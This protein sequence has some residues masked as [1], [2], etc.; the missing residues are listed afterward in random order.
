MPVEQTDYLDYVAH[1]ASVG[2][3]N[4][5]ARLKAEKFAELEQLGR[6]MIKSL[7]RNCAYIGGNGPHAGKVLYIAPN[8]NGIIVGKPITK[9]QFVANYADKMG[10][11]LEVRQKAYESRNDLVALT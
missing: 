6:T 10:L 1:E 5:M 7:N 4:A 9:D 11:L 8:E 3:T 2:E